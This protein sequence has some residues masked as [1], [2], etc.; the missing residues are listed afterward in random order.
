MTYDFRYQK[1]WQLERAQGIARTHPADKVR[2]HIDA[3]TRAGMSMRSIAAASGVSVSGIYN[4]ATREQGTVRV[5]IERR[6]LAVTVSKIYARPDRAGFVPNLGA[7]RRIEALLALGWRH[8]DITAAM[9]GVRTH[10]S[11]VLHQVGEWISGDTHDA[12]DAAYRALGGRQGPSETTRRRAKALGYVPPAAWDDD[13]IDDP[14]AVPDTGDT[15]RATVDLDEWAHLV[16][17]GVNPDDAARRCG[18]RAT[19]PVNTIDVLARR[20]GRADII[21]LLYATWVGAA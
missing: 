18:V 13:A 19:K 6:I 9:P 4:L 21:E 2:A 10:S 3:L 1:R 12:V 20:A 17:G 8:S 15:T 16:R 5:H 11:I 7:R 14:Q